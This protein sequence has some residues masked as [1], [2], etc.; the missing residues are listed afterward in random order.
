MLKILPVIFALFLLTGCLGNTSVKKD[1]NPK[2]TVVYS[3][4]CLDG[5]EYLQATAIYNYG[6][7]THLDENGKPILCEGEEK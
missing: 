7:T 5:I 2:S 4:I 3:Y 6:I 1:G